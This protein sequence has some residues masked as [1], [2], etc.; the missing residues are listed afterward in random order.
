M[1]IV[2]AH[3]SEVIFNQGYQ[4]YKYTLTLPETFLPGVYTY[5]DFGGW[6]CM[7][8]QLSS[9][10][11]QYA[12]KTVTC[13][14]SLNAVGDADNAEIYI[15][16]MILVD[17]CENHGVD[18]YCSICGA[19]V[20]M[21][22]DPEITEPEVTEPE[23]TEPEVTEP[24]ELA[25]LNINKIGLSF[26]DYIGV[27]FR[28]NK[29]TGYDAVYA[30]TSQVT[31]DTTLGDFTVVEKTLEPIVSGS[32]G[33]YYVFDQP[34]LANAMT[35]QI[36]VTVYAEKEGVVYK[37][38]TVVTSVQDQAIEKCGSLLTSAPGSVTILVNMLNY[39]ATLQTRF[40]H[41]PNNLPDAGQYASYASETVADLTATSSTIGSG[42]I[43]IDKI[44]LSMQDK[45]EL[46]ARM[47]IKIAD[48]DKYEV[49]YT[50]E[51]DSKVYVIDGADFVSANSSGS[52]S[53]ARIAVKANCMRKMHTIE[54]YEKATN[55][56]V[57]AT[58]LCSVETQGK[59][60]LGTVNN[61]LI[62][63]L[64]KYGDSVATL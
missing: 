54:V 50:V 44:G 12:G 18:G 3:A 24:V 47:V 63:A 39:G 32:K 42:A 45:V 27:N 2:S 1:N 17:L 59:D 36:T 52:K 41:N 23:V 55:T 7:N 37:S 51:G 31:W 10:L 48:A 20:E 14:L 62:I 11:V 35:E 13:Y 4:F 15:D 57:S 21:P 58:Y 22:E 26:Q 46:Q 6:I 5:V 40:G 60:H 28:I 56:C 16:Q 53:I 8:Y 29:P 9:D 49:R 43:T 38:A 25:A 61:D 33:Q 30:I 19:A 34:V 64:M